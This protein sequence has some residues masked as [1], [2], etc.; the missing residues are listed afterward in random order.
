MD[1]QLD[2]PWQ[3]DQHDHED[4]AAWGRPSATCTTCTGIATTITLQASPLPATTRDGPRGGGE[5]QRRPI[6]T[7]QA[8]DQQ[9][10]ATTF[11]EAP[12]ATWLLPGQGWWPRPRRTTAQEANA[13]WTVS[14]CPE[15]RGYQAQLRAIGA[16]RTGDDVCTT[17]NP[18]PEWDDAAWPYELT[19]DGGA[20][21]VDGTWVAGAGAVLWAHHLQGP[22]P[23]RLASSVVAIPWHAGAQVAEAIGCRAALNLLA[24][25]QPRLR[26]ARIVGDN[27]G[28]IR[29]CAGTARLRRLRMQSHLE[30]G[31]AQV[32]SQGWRLSWQA[33]RRRLNQDADAEATDGVHW[34]A[35]LQAQGQRTLRTRTTWYAAAR[36]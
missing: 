25:L 14:R 16:I 11:A 6:T 21:Q 23:V 35:Q 28:V 8:Q 30:P 22:L 2:E 31:L 3:L 7:V 18:S 19:F 12:I 5:L 15:C 20:R 26:A 10:L 13:I 4:F 27:L 33:V 9:L 17:D 29:Y 1:D 24:Q 36:R 32:L 34:A